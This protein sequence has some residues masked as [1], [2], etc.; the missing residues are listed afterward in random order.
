[1][2]LSCLVGNPNYE[3]LKGIFDAD[4][5]NQIKMGIEEAKKRYSD[6]NLVHNVTISFVSKLSTKYKKYAN[7]GGLCYNHGKNIQINYNIMKETKAPLRIYIRC[8]LS[9]ELAHSWQY[10]C[11]GQGDPNIDEIEAEL[12]SLFRG[13]INDI[14]EGKRDNFILETYYTLTSLILNDNELVKEYNEFWGAEDRDYKLLVSSKIKAV[15]GNEFKEIAK[16]TS[17]WK[18]CTT[19]VSPQII[20][21]DTSQK[22]FES[23]CKALEVVPIISASD[24]SAYKDV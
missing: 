1:M 13:A 8:L 9:H 17:L 11:N 14:N 24:S 18:Y 22:N 19:I 21:K 5:L 16:N 10:S 6:Y 12:I 3:I 7:H 2:E 15:P 23:R 20:I 4:E